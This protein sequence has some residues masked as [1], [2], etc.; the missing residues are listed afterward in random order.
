MK[1]TLLYLLMASIFLHAESLNEE[2]ER[3]KKENELLELKQKNKQLSQDL[4]DGKVTNDATKNNTSDNTPI[5]KI[6]KEESKS[7]FFIGLEGVIGGSSFLT[8]Q[9]DLE[10]IQNGTPGANVAFANDQ[11][12]FD[13]GLLFGGQKYFG[14]TQ[15]HGIKLSVHLYSGLGYTREIQTDAYHVLIPLKIGADLKYLWDF[16]DNKKHILG[17]NAGGGYEFDY[18]F[19]KYDIKGERE[20]GFNSIT[21]IASSGF[22][23]TIG[24]HYIYNR[25]HQI[26]LNYR[27][28]GILAMLGTTKI[29][30]RITN[31]TTYSYLTL[32]YAYRF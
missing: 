32:N 16:W 19:G 31:L 21:S 10:I 2:I 5:I 4:Q 28:G 6:S 9:T 3:L 22:Y 23:P 8:Y 13:G 20:E 7:G 14:Q 30:G 15:R 1:K 27:F 29:L 24:L 17:F 18:Y 12:S 25:H 26:E 11:I